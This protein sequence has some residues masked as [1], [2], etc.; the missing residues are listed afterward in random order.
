MKK[1]LSASVITLMITG[2][3]A[4]PADPQTER[5]I[6][7][8]NPAPKGCKYVGQV[9]GNQGNFFT[10]GFTSNR[11]LEEGAMNDLKNKASKK[12]ANYIQLV[13]NRA[14]VT[15]SMSG[16]FDRHGG[17]MSGGSEQTNVTNLGNAYICPPKAIGLE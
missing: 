17:F 14:G 13:T 16:S 9:V 3:A 1:L 7:S 4:I 6:A 8:P 2:C 15:G 5:V 11:N 12:G 10:G